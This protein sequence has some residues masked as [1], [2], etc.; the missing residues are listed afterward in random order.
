[1]VASELLAAFTAEPGS[2]EP[3]E[4]VAAA[5]DRALATARAA[6]PAVT[7]DAAAWMRWLGGL[8]PL[9]VVADAPLGPLEVTDLYVAFAA[10]T[11]DAPA[12][13][14]CDELLVRE[15]MVAAARV[16]VQ[17]AVRD[18]ACQ[19]VRAIVFVARG[20]RPPAIL[21]Y[22]GRGR[23]AGWLRAIL[24]RELVRLARAGQRSVPLV[25][26]LLEAPDDALDPELAAVK[27]RHRDELGD[28][29]RAALGELTARDRTL[30]RYQVVDGL[31]LD[32][33][34]AIYGVHRAT[35]CRWLADV[36]D[37]LAEATRARLKTALGVD[38]VQAASIIRM[39]HSQ[40]DVSVIRHLKP[41]R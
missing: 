1:V 14:A 12:V 23:L 26:E 34:G 7:V 29:F 10:G 25:D 9:P 31:A 5:L 18:E 3:A 39:V 20:E 22:S 16:R 37:R 38:T 8:V 33:I 35:A 36:R 27:Q 13:A 15:A 32:D 4:A 28:A 2:V 11:G 17:P 40:L 21:G 19:I 6:W 24:A 41:R 30:L